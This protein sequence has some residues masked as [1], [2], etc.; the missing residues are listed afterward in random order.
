VAVYQDTSQMSSTNAWADNGN[1]P[2]VAATGLVYL[3]NTDVSFG[4]GSGG[5][6][7]GVTP[8]CFVAIFHSYDNNGTALNMTRTGCAAAG[9]GSIPTIQLLRAA[10]VQ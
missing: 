7:V 9:L 1:S 6:P 10:L 4:G 5:F 8:T 2:S 3:P